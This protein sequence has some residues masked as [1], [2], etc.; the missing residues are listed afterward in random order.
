MSAVSRAQRGGR[1]SYVVRT[2]KR[3]HRIQQALELH[4]SSP[5]ASPAMFAFTALV[6]LASAAL[7]QVFAHGG[8]LSYKIGGTTYQGWAPYNSPTGQTSIQRPWSSYN[9]I[10]DATDS[11]LACNDDGKSGA[12]QLTATAVAG[13]PITAYW[14]QVWPHPYGPMLTYLAQCP[15]STCTGVDA[16]TLSWFKI[17]QS[18]LISGTVG[19][20]YW[21]S[22][23]MID[24][25]STWT[26]TIPASV[27]SGNYLIRFETIALHSLPAQ[28]YPE[29]AQLTITGGGSRQPTASELVKFPGG[30]SNSDPGLNVDLYSNAALTN[31]NY[32]IPGPPLYGSSATTTS[33]G[34]TTTVKT[35]TAPATTTTAAG[36]VAHYGQCGGIGYTGATGCVA[37]YTCTVLNDYFSQCT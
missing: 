9:P 1:A 20:G 14:N 2:R 18:G 33:A 32:I 23:K 27:P 26:T 22:G 29:C 13:Q 12:L 34:S 10:M 7:P 11:T 19:N 31:T 37:P 17:D 3:K 8:V 16:S 4:S 25:N 36:T 28:L 21:G 5:P 30:Y 35:T 6:A 24:Q 15:G